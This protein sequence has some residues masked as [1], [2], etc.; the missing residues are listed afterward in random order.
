MVGAP[1][2][3]L[4]VAL[5]GIPSAGA[6][7]QVVVAGP[8]TLVGL[9]S[10]SVFGTFRVNNFGALRA[11]SSTRGTTHGGTEVT[12]VGA[13]LDATSCQD[14]FNNGIIGPLWSS[15]DAGGG[16]STEYV[17]PDAGLELWTGMSGGTA[18]IRSVD[19]RTSLDVSATFRMDTSVGRLVPV[20]VASLALYAS[21]GNEFRLEV[22]AA[23]GTY[24][25]VVRVLVDGA[26]VHFTKTPGALGVS[27][28]EL[29]ILRHGRVRG[30]VNGAEVIDAGFV[31]GPVSHEMLVRGSAD[32][33]ART[34]LERYVWSPVVTFDDEAA[35][36][37]R[38]LTDGAVLVVSPPRAL[39]GTVD[40]EVVGCLGN[41]SIV[42]GFTYDYEDAV[43]VGTGG[44]ARLLVTV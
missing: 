33:Y 1:T 14:A 34:V 22:W 23:N 42:D 6:F 15:L 29:R 16:Q 3:G 13:V 43:V 19:T 11:L 17:A 9:A 18:G 12:L 27:G 39:P 20:V 4:Q 28:I 38:R 10:T 25:T 37:S 32:G 31:S 44:E 36:L 24:F 41:E 5:F 7:G 35:S 8:V 21:A 40:V 30:F 2:L 26:L